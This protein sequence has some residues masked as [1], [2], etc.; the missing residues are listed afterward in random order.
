MRRSLALV[1]TLIGAFVLF[2]A[3]PAAAATPTAAFSKTSTWDSGYQ[4][5]YTITNGGSS[6]LTSWTVEFDLPAGTSVG[7]YWDALLTQS[8]SHYTFKNREYN[9][10]LAPGASASFGW[11]STGTGTPTNC[12]LNGAPCGGGSGGGDTTAPSVPSG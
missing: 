11:V 5:A 2:L 7:S 10:S 4:G 9:G 3:P 6:Q 1:V 12:K 8:G